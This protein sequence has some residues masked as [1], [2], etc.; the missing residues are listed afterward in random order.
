MSWKDGCCHYFHARIKVQV[1]YRPPLIFRGSIVKSQLSTR[2][3]LTSLQQVEGEVCHHRQVEMKVQVFPVIFTDILKGWSRHLLVR[4]KIPTSHS[5]SLTLPWQ[6]VVWGWVPCYSLVR[7]KFC[8]HFVF[9][10]NVGRG[11][12]HRFSCGVDLEFSI[13]LFPPS[14]GLLSGD[15]KLF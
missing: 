11:V 7:V 3:P 12:V 14:P 4:M 15:N 8:T 10:D 6:E 13:L 9:A 5:H 2:L 1:L